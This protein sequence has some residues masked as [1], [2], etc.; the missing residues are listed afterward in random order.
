MSSCTKPNSCLNQPE[1]VK[2][3]CTAV[4]YLPGSS[5]TP[6][7]LKPGHEVGALDEALVEL[8]TCSLHKN[9]LA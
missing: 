6:S 2:Q 8:N 1:A 4:L 3:I 9:S 7:S 5:R